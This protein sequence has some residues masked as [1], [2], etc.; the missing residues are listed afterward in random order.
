[1]DGKDDVRQ[2]EKRGKKSVLR[3]HPLFFLLGVCYSF[4][5][6]LPAFFLSTVV[7]L[8]HECAHAF[9]AAKR[10]Y[11]LNR[12][13]LMPYGAVI[14]GDFS[15]ASF[16][17]EVAVAVWGPLANLMTAIAFVALWCGFPESYPYT[18][19]AFYASMSVALVNLLPAYP[20]DGGRILC[21]F[22]R[23]KKGEKT[24]EKVGRTV[25]L[26]F[27]TA[28]FGWFLVKLFQGELFLSLGV[29]AAFLLVGAFG[30]RE[31]AEYTKIRYDFTDFLSRGAEV[32]RVA[33]LTDC[34]LKTALSHIERGRYLVLDIYGEDERKVGEVGQNRLA[35]LFENGSINDKIGDFL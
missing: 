20:L 22:L 29:F 2:G 23:K 19:A 13:V 10:G 11:E 14:D 33:V 31:R 34:T 12:V 35:V 17:D 7:A 9:A 18:D 4:T 6:E 25:T 21:A 30:N 5:G 16:G 8:E 3:I 26:C 1:M 28:F 24:A 32:K 15:D 27:A